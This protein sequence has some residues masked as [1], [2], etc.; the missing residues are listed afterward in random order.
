MKS[1]WIKFVAAAILC[2]LFGAVIGT[3]G[4]MLYRLLT[5]QYIG[6]S[7]WRSFF[8]QVIIRDINGYYILAAFSIIGVLTQKFHKLTIPAMLITAIGAGMYVGLQMKGYE[9]AEPILYGISGLASVLMWL[10]LR[11]FFPGAGLAN[12]Y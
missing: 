4:F 10:L 9:A 6:F 11:N 3:A 8:E 7:P 12:D 1:N 5:G 2:P